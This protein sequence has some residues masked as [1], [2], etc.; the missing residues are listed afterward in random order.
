MFLSKI[1]RRKHWI[2]YNQLPYISSYDNR[3]NLYIHFI[4]KCVEHLEDDGEMILITPREFI[5]ATS[6]IK[7]NNFLY[8]SGTITDWYEYGDTSCF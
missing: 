7:L 4:R 2:K 6:S 1:L 8:D 3:T 5:K